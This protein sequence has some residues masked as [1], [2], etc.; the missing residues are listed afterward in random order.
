MK[1]H[2]V[3]P[4]RPK[5]VPPRPQATGKTPT[6]PDPIPQTPSPLT[7][8]M[9]SFLTPLMLAAGLTDT[10]LARRAAQEAI[11]AC[12]SG[13]PLT[14]SAQAIGFAM[15]ALDSLRLAAAPDVAVTTKLRLR[16][17]ANALN[18]SSQRSAGSQPTSQH[19]VPQP[20]PNRAVK[21]AWANA[22]TDVAAECAR[23]LAKL[24][25]HQRR[26]EVIRINA[27]R[28]TAHQIRGAESSAC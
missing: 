3:K 14:A 17:N 24:P 20:K 2:R 12:P 7:Q 10:A 27:L 6:M 9:L 15:A 18:R 21:R 13:A 4:N 26:A 16:G 11:A 23:D 8:V 5:T 19:T 28:A 22:M 1:R 25:P